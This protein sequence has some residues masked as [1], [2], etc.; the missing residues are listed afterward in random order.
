MGSSRNSTKGILG[1]EVSSEDGVG[2]GACSPPKNARKQE[3]G[4]EMSETNTI[5]MNEYNLCD[6]I[7][8]LRV[9]ISISGTSITDFED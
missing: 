9:F 3:R 6:Y 8:V 7:C 5:D 4:E 1:M 2:T